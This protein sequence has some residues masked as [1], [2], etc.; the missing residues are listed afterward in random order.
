MSVK[1]FQ[2]AFQRIEMYTVEVA[3]SSLDEAIEIASEEADELARNHEPRNV[4]YDY[5]EEA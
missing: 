1:T 3:A 2:I 4:E 5:F